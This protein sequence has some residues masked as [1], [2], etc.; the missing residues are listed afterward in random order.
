[1]ALAPLGLSVFL[2]PRSLGA[3]GM[4]LCH[5]ALSWH[6]AELARGGYII[7]STTYLGSSFISLDSLLLSISPTTISL[8]LE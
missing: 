5:I 6:I 3:I 2:A 7:Y 8:S 4:S 1:M